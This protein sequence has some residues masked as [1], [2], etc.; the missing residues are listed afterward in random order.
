MFWFWVFFL[1]NCFTTY[2]KSQMMWMLTTNPISWPCWELFGIADSMY[3]WVGKC[4][5][6][7][8][9]YSCLRCVSNLGSITSVRCRSNA[10]MAWEF[11]LWLI[12]ERIVAG[13][14]RLC[15]QATRSYAPVTRKCSRCFLMF[16]MILIICSFCQLLSSWCKIIPMKHYR[17]IPVLWG[18]FPPPLLSLI[19]TFNVGT[20]I[21][22]RR[23]QSIYLKKKKSSIQHV[24]LKSN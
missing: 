7:E 12:S 2:A 10:A 4:L 14:G 9:T 6:W 22:R 11:L 17:K 16:P 8:E 13:A 3:L 21:G 1:A 24:M 19:W 18:F 15:Y 23:Q 5:K 20:F